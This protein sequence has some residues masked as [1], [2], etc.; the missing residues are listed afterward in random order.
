MA[1][2][3]TKRAVY[4]FAAGAV[5][6]IPALLLSEAFQGLPIVLFFIYNI[7]LLLLIFWD[8]TSNEGKNTLKL[9]RI[10]SNKLSLHEEEEIF[11]EVLNEGN[12]ELH[13][14]IFQITILFV[15]MSL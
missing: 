9:K 1:L 13:V 14:M 15:K 5:F 11:F 10:G 7:A 6:L 12:R 4:L 3:I 8:Y 2:S